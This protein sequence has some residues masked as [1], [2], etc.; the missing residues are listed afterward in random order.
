MSPVSLL[1]PVLCLALTGCFA[2]TLPAGDSSGW[3]NVPARGV[4]EIRVEDSTLDACELAPLF[5][6]QP[7]WNLAL[8]E[9]ARDAFQLAQPQT[10]RTVMCGHANPGYVCF[11]SDVGTWMTGGRELAVWMDGEDR[12][13]GF[14]IRVEA[15]ETCASSGGGCAEPCESEFVLHVAGP[16]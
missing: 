9:S 5:T 6:E 2:V 15:L 1:I 8:R 13:D 3:P 4:Y 11:E 10:A 12:S 7:L 14:A 16:G